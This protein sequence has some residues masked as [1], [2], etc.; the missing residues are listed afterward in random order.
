C[1]EQPAECK[2]AHHRDPEQRTGSD[3]PGPDH[4][5]RDAE[6]PRAL[7]RVL[8]RLF[9]SSASLQRTLTASSPANKSLRGGSRGPETG[10]RGIPS[11]FIKIYERGR[12][13]PH[14]SL[15]PLLPPRKDLFAGVLAFSHLRGEH[16][17]ALGA[18]HE[19]A[20]DEH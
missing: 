17:L 6:Q 5:F 3:D 18:A 13:T 2:G 20:G 8:A 16:A 9:D 7:K 10:V 15:P 12:D 14:P 1:V 11:P 19:V 4:D